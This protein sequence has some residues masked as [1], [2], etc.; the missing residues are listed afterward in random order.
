MN[1]YSRLNSLEHKKKQSVQEQID[2]F[3]Q[4]FQ[5]MYDREPTQEEIENERQSIMK[6]KPADI[7]QTAAEIDKLVYS[8]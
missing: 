4:L 3:I 6:R 5:L 7:I 2:T 8:N 1:C